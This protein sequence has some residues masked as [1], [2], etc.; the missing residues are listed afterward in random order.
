MIKPSSNDG[1]AVEAGDVCQSCGGV[2][3]ETSSNGSEELSC[4]C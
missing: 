4:K 1:K 3:I 2:V